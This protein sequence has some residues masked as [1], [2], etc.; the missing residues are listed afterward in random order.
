MPT[1]T[2]GDSDLVYEQSGRGPDV[3]WI[4]GGGDSGAPWRRWQTPAF[5]D[6]FR[7][8]LNAEIRKILERR[9]A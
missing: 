7:S 2:I 1:V 4:A 5:D 8:T 9:H 6:A 3:L